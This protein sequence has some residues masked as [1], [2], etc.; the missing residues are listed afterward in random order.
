MGMVVVIGH[1]NLRDDEVSQ[2]H[3]AAE[4][5]IGI[6]QAKVTVCMRMRV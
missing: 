1:T 2:V 3:G 4:E 5:I 6:L